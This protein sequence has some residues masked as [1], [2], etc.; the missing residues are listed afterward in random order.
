M[1]AFIGLRK[2]EMEV[3]S[4]IRFKNTCFAGNTYLRGMKMMLIGRRG[5][6]RGQGEGG[7]DE[8]RGRK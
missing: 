4:E 1:V 2:G 5:R 6:G 3:K 8:G 7:G